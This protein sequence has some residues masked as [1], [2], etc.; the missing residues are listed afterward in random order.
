M[1]LLPYLHFFSFNL[2]IFLSIYIFLKNR[3][4]R[5]NQTMA[6]S[7]TGL[8][9]W[10]FSM[11]FI[12]NPTVTKETAHLFT[13][14]GALGW[15]SFSSLFLWFILELSR[16][17]AW[18][19]KRWT[20]TALFVPP[21]FFLLVQWSNHLFVDHVQ[22]NYGWKPIYSDAFWP[23]IFASYYV[24]YMSGG[25]YLCFRMIREAREPGLVKQAKIIIATILP[26]LLFGFL[27]DTL[28]PVLGIH[29]IPNI[30][31]IL[32]FIWVFGVVYAVA[33]YKFLSINPATAA[34][35]IISTMFDSLILLDLDG[36][37][38]NTNQATS[39]LLGYPEEELKQTSFV[40][41]LPGDGSG[42]GCLAEIAGGHVKNRDIILQTRDGRHV[43]VLFSSSILKD[44]YGA[45]VGTVC[46]ARDISERKQWE[47]ESLKRKKLESL[48]IL[49]GGIAH[50]FNNLL[51]ILMGNISIA[52]S[53]LK[54][55]EHTYRFLEKAEDASKKAAKLASRFITFSDG[56]WLKNEPIRLEDL[57]ENAGQ[58]PPQAHGVTLAVDIPTDLPPVVGDLEQLEQAL[59]N[60]F[61]N[62]VEAMPGGGAIG[63]RAEITSPGEI[64][65]KLL[66]N[67]YRYITVIV[68]D[69]G[70]GIP[71][72]NL[73]KVFDPYF[74][75]KKEVSQKGLGLGLTT[76][77]SIIKKHDGHI[78]VESQEGR[79]TTV[80]L[81]L[82]VFEEKDD[83]PEQD[84]S[85]G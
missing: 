63:V 39:R 4:R 54:P 42:D 14:I 57:L 5:L 25:L 65:V 33:K 59:K 68:R 79:G 50:D 35:N 1:I 45:P 84:G 60:I 7:F 58:L 48:G 73:E 56:G 40:N 31:N 15:C 38:V 82:P 8:G 70:P 34:D 11:T 24:L 46:I 28:L 74:S 13:D 36:N 23:L 64:D 18:L 67:D 81:H 72:E 3:T 20:Y 6:L 75:T 10:S 32:V 85:K 37:I 62:A 76:S 2:Y 29:T 43:H 19:K 80:K 22:T 44:E 16:Q 26:T 49:A 71:R 9:V 53:G 21:L 78:S 69:N 12:H 47:T 55:G 51:S 27:T 77:Y 17:E 66:R 52:K 41:L 61:L 83:G 30:A